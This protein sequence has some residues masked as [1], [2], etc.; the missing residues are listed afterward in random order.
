MTVEP[1]T[2]VKNSN[3]MAES[4][5]RV[6]ADCVN[7][8]MYIMSSKCILIGTLLLIFLFPLSLLRERLRVLRSL[9]YISIEYTRDKNQTHVKTCR[10]SAK[11]ATEVDRTS[12]L[13][14][15]TPSTRMTNRADRAKMR[16]YLMSD[17]QA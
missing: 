16:T 12:A 3:D 13:A 8:M 2:S 10:P 7:N 6:F 17:G 9:N 14:P 1:F 5:R 4:R 15:S 11:P